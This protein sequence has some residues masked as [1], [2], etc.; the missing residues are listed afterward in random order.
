MSDEEL[1]RIVQIVSNIKGIDSA[2]LIPAVSIEQEFH[3]WMQTPEG[4]FAQ[5]RAEN[6][7]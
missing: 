3:Q 7:K 6:N 4:R 5:Y 1:N 2:I